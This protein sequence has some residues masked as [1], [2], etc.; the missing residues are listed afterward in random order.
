MFADVLNFF[1]MWAWPWSTNAYFGMFFRN[2][3]LIYNCWVTFQSYKIFIFQSFESILYSYVWQSAITR[4]IKVSK[5]WF[6]RV[7]LRFLTFLSLFVVKYMNG[8]LTNTFKWYTLT[9]NYSGGLRKNRLRKVLN[10][11]Q[12]HM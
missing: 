1:L 3:I 9:F 10:Q 2:Q 5:F 4:K 11:Y 7:Q 12:D 6:K 8:Y